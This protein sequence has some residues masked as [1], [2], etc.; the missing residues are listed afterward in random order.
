MLNELERGDTICILGAPRKAHERFEAYLIAWNKE[1]VARGIRSRII[2]NYNCKRFGRAREKMPLTEVRYLQRG[3]E[4]PA[5]IDIFKDYVVTINCYENP[6]CFLMRS[7]DS[8]ETYRKYF[9]MLWK[10]AEK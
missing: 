1:R 2:L 7:R 10:Q 6:L 8:A 9:D 5:V 3:L 4:T